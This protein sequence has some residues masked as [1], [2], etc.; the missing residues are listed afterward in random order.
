MRYGL[1][2][3]CAASWFV[4]GVA[5]YPPRPLQEAY[6]VFWAVGGPN[7]TAFDHNGSVN[8]AQYGIKP[9]NF[10]VCGGLTGGWPDLQG[11]GYP[12]KPVNGG[13]P[14]AANLSLFLDA[15]HTAVQA[16]IP[17]ED[18]TGL[19]IFDVRPQHSV[20]NLMA[21]LQHTDLVP[22]RA[23]SSKHGYPSGR[24]TRPQ[25]ASTGIRRVFKITQWSWCSRS[26][27]PG[28]QHKSRNRLRLSLRQPGRRCLSQPLST[29][30]RCAPKRSGA[31]TVRA[32]ATEPHY[33]LYHTD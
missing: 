18:W 30:L 12:F 15:L 9:N 5:V 1:S 3:A 22:L 13:V 10:T 23:C 31:S 11:D 6:P 29:H 27:R 8:V 21:A 16:K 7:V 20:P 17:D 28:P 24:T 33:S 26:T 2:A 19:G 32:G 14:Q 4:A 25:L